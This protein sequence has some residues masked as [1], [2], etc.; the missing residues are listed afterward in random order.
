[1]TR[2][3]MRKRRTQV[4]VV[5]PVPL[6]EAGWLT[7]CSATPACDCWV[8]SPRRSGAGLRSPV[9]ARTPIAAGTALAPRRFPV[10]A[11]A[12]VATRAAVKAG[13]ALVLREP[14]LGRTP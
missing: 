6:V 9:A 8:D 3:D 5:L 11:G 14:R 1:M 12:T 4:I 7:P 2:L 10:N 13:A